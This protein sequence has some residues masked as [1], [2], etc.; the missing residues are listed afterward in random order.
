MT[1]LLLGLLA[2]PV[3]LLVLGL[4]GSHLATEPGVRGD[5]L[6]GDA[7]RSTLFVLVHGMTPDDEHWAE[8]ARS[9]EPHGQVL[10]LR[11]NAARWSNADPRQVAAGIGREV[12]AAVDATGAGRVR[13]VA[14]SMGALL[15]RRAL[16]DSR[17]QAWLGRVDR[18][19][20][21]AGVNR[22]W[23]LSGEPPADADPLYR[24][25]MR[26]GYW[27]A[28]MVSMS[29]LVFS[30]ERGSPFVADLR[31]EWMSWMRELKSPVEV[32]QLL[33]DIDDVVGRED[34]EDLRVIASKRFAQM[35]VRG[36]N[37]GDI[38]NFG[39]E[40]EPCSAE[41]ALGTYRRDKLVTA[42]T[43]PFETV[44]TF[45][46]ALPHTPDESITDI[47]FVLHGIRDLG[48][49]SAEFESAIDRLYPGR[50]DH[51]RVVSSR[52]GYF[53]M[54][55]FLF[56]DVRNRYVR[57][58]MDQYTETL[59][60]YPSVKP[61]KIR[62]FGHSNGTYLVAEALAEYQAM[63]FDRVVFAGSVVPRAYPWS[64]LMTSQAAGKEPRVRAMR[65][66]VGTEDWVV[67]LFP[68]LFELPVVS[69]LGNSIGSA[70]FNGFDDPKVDNVRF[71]KGTH[72]AFESRVDEIVTFL[73]DPAVPATAKH[74]NRGTVGHV[75][76][77]W[78]VV[79]LVWALL[80]LIVLALGARVVGASSVPVW[81]ALLVY[82]LVV[83]AI[84]RTV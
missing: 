58:F 62:F 59:A 8:V 74:E 52:Y 72:S 33:G 54:G 66:Y 20:L 60:R 1:Y 80:A 37:H 45:N 22:G 81:P 30:F 82:L 32:V 12:K 41:R 84:L 26:L 79:V 49:W 75:L 78:P 18:V 40:A 77:A 19:V 34:N 64:P 56:E 31:L 55:P 65:N 14:H 68:R 44:L 38:V 35:H 39:G 24:L 6:S 61:G 42:A 11:Y 69:L 4:F 70:G 16:L 23:D 51:L 73:L 57:W 43:A 53:G 36:T 67:A 10:R 47:V 29:K 76:S 48:R 83:T 71:V 27:A 25:G 15:T 13:F 9:L 7:T 46:E 21:L 5:P 50:R 2:F 28:H 17:G 63:E 3:V